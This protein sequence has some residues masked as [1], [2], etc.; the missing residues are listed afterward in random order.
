[1]RVLGLGKG[2]G[3]GG[4]GREEGILVLFC[5]GLT[6]FGEELTPAFFLAW[7]REGLGQTRDRAEGVSKCPD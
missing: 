7:L 2:G 6:P 4:G 3:L 5:S 1:M